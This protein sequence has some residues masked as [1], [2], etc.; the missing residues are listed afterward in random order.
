MLID[1]NNSFAPSPLILCKQFFFFIFY[2]IFL[3]FL[4]EPRVSSGFVILLI[5]LLLLLLCVYFVIDKIIMA[6]TC[7]NIIY[8]LSFVNVL[9]LLYDNKES[10]TH[11]NRHYIIELCWIQRNF[12]LV[13]LKWS[14]F[15]LLNCNLREFVSLG[16]E[17]SSKSIH[18]SRNSTRK[19]F[20]YYY[21]RKIPNTETFKDYQQPE[22]NQKNINIFKATTIEGLMSCQ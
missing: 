4:C 15:G 7:Y 20:T 14:I 18:F 16:V 5:L 22:F 1:N 12:R 2:F 17:I 21:I 11:Y 13:S 3:L 6:E 10:H 19:T 8:I 9:L